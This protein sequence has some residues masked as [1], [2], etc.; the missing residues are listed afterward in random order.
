MLPG[1]TQTNG[2]D[3]AL[4]DTVAGS[5]INLTIL[6]ST[7]SPNVALGQFGFPVQHTAAGEPH[8][9]RVREILSPRDVLQIAGT[10]IGLVSIDVI[11]FAAFWTWS[12]ECRS[13][14]TVNGLDFLDILS[15]ETN[16]A[17]AVPLRARLEDVVPAST[18]ITVKSADSPQRTGLVQAL[19]PNNGSPLFNEEGRL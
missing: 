8:R 14:H 11:D 7:D 12:M 3:E 10:V 9:I 2:A 1:L 17:I 18:R 13:D 15:I 4:N 16:Q 6:A 19:I 5:Q